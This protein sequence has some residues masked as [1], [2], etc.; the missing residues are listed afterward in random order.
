MLACPVKVILN[1]YILHDW[2]ATIST[3]DDIDV[4]VNQVQVQYPS[5]LTIDPEI[6]KTSLHPST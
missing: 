2:E 1:V 6:N 5:E 4:K 3:L